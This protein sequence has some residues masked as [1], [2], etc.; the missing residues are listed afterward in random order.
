[1]IGSVGWVSLVLM[2]RY[3]DS[4]ELGEGVEP[5][6]DGEAEVGVGGVEVGEVGCVV[7]AGEEDALEDL[8][9]QE[10]AQDLHPHRGRPL[11]PLR[12]A[13]EPQR[14]RR[15]RRRWWFRS[16][17]DSFLLRRG[18]GRE[19]VR[20]RLAAEQTRGEM[21]RTARSAPHLDEGILAPQ[22]I[23]TQLHLPT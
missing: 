9:G 2:N 12:T 16:R 13:D 14:R 15:R 10:A 22:A 4:E 19:A 6:G 18:G 21:K 23:S 20:G 11:F 7:A 5:G 17:P 1:M 3:K 8:V